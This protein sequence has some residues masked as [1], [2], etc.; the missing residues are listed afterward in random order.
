[1]FRQSRKNAIN[2]EPASAPTPLTFQPYFFKVIYISNDV[3]RKQEENEQLS[4]WCATKVTQKTSNLEVT[5]ETGVTQKNDSLRGAR[6][7]P[8]GGGVGT[9]RQQCSVLSSTLMRI[10]LPP[11]NG[12]R[13]TLSFDIMAENMCCS[14]ENTSPTLKVR[15]LRLASCAFSGFSNRVATCPGRRR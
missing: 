13:A 15:P 5:I 10:G 14:P 6:T 9:N 12:E 11:R 8:G 7:G 2:H 3:L 4:L 1:M